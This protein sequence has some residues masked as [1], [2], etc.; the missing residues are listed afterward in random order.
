MTCDKI[1]ICEKTC[2]QLYLSCTLQEIECS[3]GRCQCKSG[4]AR[5]P[6]ADKCVPTSKCEDFKPCSA[7]EEWFPCGQAKYCDLTCGHLNEPCRRLYNMRC[8]EG[9]QCKD[10]FAR[11]PTSRR[12]EPINKCPDYKPL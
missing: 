1:E 6:K 7:N 2:G 10:G 4:F 11:N 8:P 5:H 12:C 3:I 9:C